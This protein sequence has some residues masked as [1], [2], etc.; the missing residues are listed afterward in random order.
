[1]SQT[2]L[3]ATVGAFGFAAGGVALTVTAPPP[4]PFEAPQ[5]AGVA[6]AVDAPAP[7]L[8]RTWPAVFGAEVIPEPEPEPEPEPVAVAEPEPEIRY[9]Y[10]LT[11][12][13]AD[14]FDAWAMISLGGQQ[15]VV[16]VGDELEGGEIVTA[17][18]H[19]GVW[20]TWRDLPQLIPVYKPDTDH[21]ARDLAAEKP[22]APADP[23]GE[24]SVVLERMDDAFLAASFQSAGTLVRSD[25]GDGTF[26]LDV[27]WIRQGE[28]YDQ[29]GLRTGDKILRINGE[30]LENESLLANVSAGITN[31]GSID[32]EILRDGNRQIIKVNLGQG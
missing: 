29:I 7:R 13:I 10:Q 27:V 12:L 21:L 2:A 5:L 16:R 9:D 19:Q 30:A 11:G 4:P 17:I 28:L 14:S 15:S 32:L 6:Q 18:D 8:E 20:I 24:V 31:G 3:A 23:L 26:G 22:A 25:L 1:M